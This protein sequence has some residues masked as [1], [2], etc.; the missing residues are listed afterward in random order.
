MPMYV[1]LC[2]YSQKG[3]ESIGDSPGRTEESRKL[4]RRMGG[5]YRDFYLVFGQYDLVVICEFPDDETAAA[6]ALRNNR[7]GNVRTETLRAFTEEQFA[8]FVGSA[9]S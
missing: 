5:E 3:I 7:L 4:A 8:S 1:Y 6:F 9:G 2:K